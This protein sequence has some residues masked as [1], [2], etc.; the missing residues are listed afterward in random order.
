[1]SFS[2]LS[3]LEGVQDPRVERTRLHPL[4]AILGIALCAVLCGADSFVEMEEFGKAKEEWLATWLPL[5][6]G[7]P[8]HDTFAR[9]FARLEPQVLGDL[10][11]ATSQLFRGGKA[12]QICIDGEYLR[13][14]YD[15]ATGQKALVM[16]NA[17]ANGSRLVLAS[18]AVSE[19]SNEITAVPKVL[20]SLDLTGCVVT[21]DAMGCQKKIARQIVSGGG[22]YFLALKGNHEQVHSDVAGF[23]EH[24]QSKGWEERPVEVFETFDA[25]HGRRE[26]RRLSQ[27]NLRDYGEA[28]S[29]V[30]KEWCGLKSL[31]RLD[32]EREL[33][34]KVSVETRYYLSSLVGDARRA[35]SCVRSHWGV[36]NG[37]HYVLDVAFLEDGCRVRKDYASE[38]LAHLRQLALNLLRL[39]KSSKVGVRVKRSKAGWDEGYLLKVLGS[40]PI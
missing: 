10:L 1:M 2:L 40:C 12:T 29:D 6:N 11:I 39:E 23:F 21:L 36:E 30:T 38:N 16:V 14:S 31:L 19:K 15:T 32:S 27:V 24:S 3:Y 26:R 35:L 5:E 37:L 20:S 9:L 8:S 34:G 7:I 17:W 22:D 18:V 28:W 4:P 25:E 33:D 13:H